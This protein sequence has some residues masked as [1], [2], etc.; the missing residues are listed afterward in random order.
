MYSALFTCISVKTFLLVEC[1]ETNLVWFFLDPLVALDFTLV[2]ENNIQLPCQLHS[3]LAQVL[4]RFSDQTLHSNHKYYIYGGGLLIL[5][6]SESDAGLY[7]CVSVEQINGRTYNRT[8]A[9]YRLRLYSGPDAGNSTTTVNK[10]TNSPDSIHTLT[11]ATPGP[12][13]NHDNEDLL[14]PE[15]H[16]DTGRVTHLEVAVALLSLLSLCLMG[17][18]VWLMSRGRWECS[19]FVP[20]LKSSSESEGKR[21]SCEYMHIPNRTSEVKFLGPDSARP[22]AANNNHSAVDFKGNG[23]HLSL[24]HI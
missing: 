8:V 18:I 19:K 20:V 11:T 10:V 13:P 24:I 21:Q 15:S 23:G 14:S 5:S 7:T 16:S 17:A 4:W 2:P 9:V 1:S 12:V 3:N 22:C 6:A